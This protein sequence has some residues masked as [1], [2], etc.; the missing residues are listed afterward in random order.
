MHI[1]FYIQDFVSPVKIYSW[2]IV[3]CE[4]WMKTVFYDYYKSIFS[5]FIL[6]SSAEKFQGQEL[7]Y[8][9]FSPFKCCDLQSFPYWKLG[10]E[11][12]SDKLF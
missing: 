10:L 5:Q 6:A 11:F 3:G 1:Q 9:V 2:T 7:M 8:M 12:A 4:D